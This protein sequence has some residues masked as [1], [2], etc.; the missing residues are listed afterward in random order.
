[1]NSADWFAQRQIMDEH[2]PMLTRFG[3]ADA[4]VAIHSHM[5]SYLATVGQYFGFAAVVECPLPVLA[6]SRFAALGDVRSDVIWF[7]K[8]L[9]VPLV[10]F[11]FERFQTRGDERKLRH[12]IENLAITSLRAGNTLQHC[13]LIY[14]LRSGTAP[15]SLKESRA[16][17]RVGFVRNGVRVPPP[18]CPLT[19]V[20]CVFGWQGE[21]LLV[22]D[23]LFVESS[24][25]SW[26]T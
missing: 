8:Q 10:A 6:G 5:L 26:P 11:E 14:W 7:D 2:F 19:I 4:D 22:H 20:K 16:L 12:K 15:Q 21:K 17:Y 1:M 18:H 24:V 9:N 13:F 23:L 25:H 3:V